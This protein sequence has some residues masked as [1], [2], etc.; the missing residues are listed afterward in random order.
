MVINIWRYDCGRNGVASPKLKQ[1]LAFSTSLSRARY[2]FDIQLS[3]ED[4]A[5]M[6]QVKPI[7]DYVNTDSAE[8][9]RIEGRHAYNLVSDDPEGQ[10]QEIAIYGARAGLKRFWHIAVSSREGEHLTPEQLEHV[11]SVV[12]RVLGVADCPSIWADHRDT[13]N[14]HMH[15][16]VVSFLPAEDRP[17]T[18]GQDWWKEAGQI[19]MAII[20][21]DLD[22]EPEPNRRFVADRTG[23]YHTW[24]DI[25]VAD[26]DGKILGRSEIVAAQKAHKAWKQDNYAAKI[27]QSGEEWDMERA[28]QIL[29]K[30]RIMKSKTAAQVHESLARVGLKYV[31]GQS[32][33]RIVA[34]GYLPEAGQHAQGQSIAAS[35][36]YRNAALKKLGDR[37]TDGYQAAHPGLVVRKFVMPR[38]EKLTDEERDRFADRRAEIEECKELADHLKQHNSQFYRRMRDVEK[39]KDVNE[40]RAQRRRSHEREEARVKKLEKSLSKPFRDARVFPEEAGDTLAIVWG[41]PA[42]RSSPEKAHREAEE[43]RELEDRYRIEKTEDARKFWYGKNLAFIERLRTIEIVSQKRRA[44]IDALKLARYRFRRLRIASAQKIRKGLARIAAE[45]GIALEE[46]PLRNLALTHVVSVRAGSIRS[47]VSANRAYYD[48]WGDRKD[49]RWRDHDERRLRGERIRTLAAPDHPLHAGKLVTNYLL[50]VQNIG[51]HSNSA[52]PALETQRRIADEIDHDKLWLAPSRYQNS[53]EGFQWRFLDDPV[54]VETFKDKPHR[55]LHPAVQRDLAAIEAIQIERRRWIAAAVVA[56]AASIEDG[57]LT[58]FKDDAPWAAS[59]WKAQRADPTFQRLIAVAWARP[60]RFAYDENARPGELSQKQA[61]QNKDPALAEA[62][63]RQMHAYERTNTAMSEGN[64]AP[65][66]SAAIQSSNAGSKLASDMPSRPATSAP[67][68]AV[69]EDRDRPVG[70]RHSGAPNPDGFER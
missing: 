14:D 29:A 11:R 52:D 32:G 25:K 60:D 35:K 70:P 41:P 55:L 12:C 8:G 3:A 18:F 15:G 53:H 56:G 48:T 59:F 37:L 46:G 65:D 22:L 6:E 57:E 26:E 54:L 27:A 58:V 4:I 69:V 2:I 42:G 38:F 19:A 30:P 13:D 34:N 33:A 9:H 40:Q 10:S 21:R 66:K 49:K 23:V 43:R 50:E 62:I 17:V 16:L 67:R 68:P 45:L 20:E 24:S 51:L 61:L 5:V 47:I 1:E 63:A 7:G 64:R 28:V 39:G 36:A 31:A 44:R